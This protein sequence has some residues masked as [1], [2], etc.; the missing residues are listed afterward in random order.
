MAAAVKSLRTRLLFLLTKTGKVPN[1]TG[2]WLTVIPYMVL[3]LLGLFIPMQWGAPAGQAA[4]LTYSVAIVA[5][6]AG[7]VVEVP[8]QPNVPIEQGDVLFR[9]D[10]TPRHK[11]KHRYPD[12]LRRPFQQCLDRSSCA[13]SSM[14]LSSKR[15]CSPAPSGKLPFIRRTPRQRMSFVAS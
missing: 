6:V 8:V 15:A 14:I 11:V 13:S 7:E 4:V 5:N 12:R 9:I 1:S 2:T 3:L 10:P